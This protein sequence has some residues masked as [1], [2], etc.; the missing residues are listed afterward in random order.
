[1]SLSYND[2]NH[3]PLS[4]PSTRHYLQCPLHRAPRCFRAVLVRSLELGEGN[5]IP[6][7]WKGFCDYFGLQELKAGGA[8]EL[9]DAWTDRHPYRA[10]HTLLKVVEYA[11]STKH[12]KLLQSLGKAMQ[13]E[14]VFVHTCRVT[15]SY[16][17]H[18]VCRAYL[19]YYGLL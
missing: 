15:H 4:S 10:E 2:P 8:G 13:R 1:M 7:N 11:H 16:N 6:T 3:D 12:A 14:P 19:L 5:F 18:Q 17:T 9:V